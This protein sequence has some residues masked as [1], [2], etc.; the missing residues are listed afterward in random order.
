MIVK[1]QAMR[2]VRTPVTVFRCAVCCAEFDNEHL[3]NSH[4][5]IHEPIRYHGS[6]GYG[7]VYV[8]EKSVNN[9]SIYHRIE[10]TVDINWK[11]E[12]WYV[13]HEVQRYDSEEMCLQFI[14]LEEAI[15]NMKEEFYN[16]SQDWR[17]YHEVR[18]AGKPDK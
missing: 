7:A 12:G 6:N 16:M 18:K 17:Y 5:N 15:F 1:T 2:T 4:S 8:T 14:P 11:G 13:K 10:G 9:G 3:A